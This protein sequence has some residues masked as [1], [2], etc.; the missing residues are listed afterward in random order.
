MLVVGVIL[1]YL[2]NMK[3]NEVKWT[4]LIGGHVAYDICT[5]LY[6]GK[7]YHLICLVLIVIRKQS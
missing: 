2:Q 4:A 5:R 3:V 7:T 1:E 6:R